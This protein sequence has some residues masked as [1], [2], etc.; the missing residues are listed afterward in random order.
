M[1]INTEGSLPHIL[2][3]IS[4]SLWVFLLLKITNEIF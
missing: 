1:D 3:A 4:F 2:K